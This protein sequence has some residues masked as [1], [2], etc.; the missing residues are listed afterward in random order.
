MTETLFHKILSGDIPCKKIYE[1]EHTF[2]FLDIR[3]ATRGHMLV[4]PKE[5]S[6]NIYDISQQNLQKVVAT[7]K[8]MAERAKRVLNCTGCNIIQ[9]SGES[10]EQEVKYIHFHVIPRYDDGQFKLWSNR[11]GNKNELDQVHKLLSDEA[12]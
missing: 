6:E 2:V 7:C 4:I 9:S 10:A 11:Y 3:P 8:K 5:F 12:S 1:D